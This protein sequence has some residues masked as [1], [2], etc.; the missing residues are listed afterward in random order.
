VSNG[1]TANLHGSF[2]DMGTT[3]VTGTNGA[4]LNPSA[5]NVLTAENTL[6]RA[7]GAGTEYAINNGGTFVDKGGNSYL[8]QTS[9]FNFNTATGNA[10]WWQ[11]ARGTCTGVATASS[12]LGLYGTGPNVTLTTC[13]SAAIG[14]GFVVK[15]AGTIEILKCTSTATTVS[16]ACKVLKNGSTVGAPT[17]TMTAATLCTDNTTQLAVVIGDLVSLEIITGA[18]E[19]GANIIAYVGIK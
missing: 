6:F 13:T 14:T 4:F 7:T 17:C 8:G 3:G 10:T 16:V 15:K 18:A 9:D 19:T 11:E 5:T 2:V 12:T 1:G